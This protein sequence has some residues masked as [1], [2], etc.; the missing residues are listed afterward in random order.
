MPK[1]EVDV[2]TQGLQQRRS[3]GRRGECR[4]IVVEAEDCGRGSS[5]NIE[6]I[7]SCRRCCFSSSRDRLQERLQKV[8]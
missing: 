1:V 6:R 8:S 7:R 5:E 3:R 2:Q 4:L